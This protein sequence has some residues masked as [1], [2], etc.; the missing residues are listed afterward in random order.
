MLRHRGAEFQPT[1]LRWLQS[2]LDMEARDHGGYGHLRREQ[3][4]ETEEYDAGDR[5]TTYER[6][7]Y[8][9]LNCGEDVD[10]P[11]HERESEIAW[12]DGSA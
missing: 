6:N 1:D 12:G 8:R 10:G 7:V 4:S 5:I 2:L 9:C 11:W 3:G